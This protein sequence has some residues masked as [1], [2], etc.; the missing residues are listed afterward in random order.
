MKNSCLFRSTVAATIVLLSSPG[1]ATAQTDDFDDGNDAGWVRFEPLAPFGGTTI[2]VSDG[3]YFLTCQSSPNA[4]E[5]GPARCG[6]LLP[7]V[8]Q[9]FLVM[10]DINDFD[11]ADDTSAGILARIQPGAG[12]GNVN[13]YS[14]TYQAKDKDV[15]DDSKTTTLPISLEIVRRY[16]TH[17]QKGPWFIDLLNLTLGLHDLSI[18]CE[19]IQRYFE[20]LENDGVRITENLDFATTS[21]HN[22]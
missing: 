13:G 10:V 7:E 11:P 2:G 14:F 8:Y 15:H 4:P 20:T 6:A 3:K 1:A 21:A 5:F 12:P 19:R 17:T 22:D 9:T 16:V 18:A